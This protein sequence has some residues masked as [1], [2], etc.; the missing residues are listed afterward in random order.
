M[1]VTVSE[2]ESADT[3]TAATPVAEDFALSVSASPSASVN[4]FDSETF[5]VPLWFTIVW[6]AIADAIVG[7]LLRVCCCDGS[8]L[9]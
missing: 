5:C 7:G 8:G 3:D 2:E 6:S 1:A 9:W 4:T